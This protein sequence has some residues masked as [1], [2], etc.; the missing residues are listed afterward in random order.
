MAIDPVVPEA[1]FYRLSEELLTMIA[2]CV[3]LPDARPGHH[4][5]P[6]SDIKPLRLVHP[7]FAY[8]KC[9]PAPLLKQLTFAATPESLASLQDKKA[10]ERV[11]PFAKTVRFTPSI[12]SSLL[13]PTRS[14]QLIVE[15]SLS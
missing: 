1:A 11:R 9:V 12:F 7:K 3:G 13:G 6:W 2:E 4:R 5:L 10:L 15:T 14:K 8:L